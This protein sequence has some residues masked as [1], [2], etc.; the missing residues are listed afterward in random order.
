MR[1]HLRSPAGARRCADAR[2]ARYRGVF[3]S[4]RPDPARLCPSVDAEGRLELRRARRHHGGAPCARWNHGRARGYRHGRRRTRHMERPRYALADPRAVFQGL[5]G[6]PLGAAGDR[7][8]AR[9]E[10]HAWVRCSGRRAR[11]HRIVSRGDRSRIAVSGAGHH[12]RC[13]V[14][15]ALW[16]RGGARLRSRRR[17]RGRGRGRRRSARRASAGGDRA[18]GGCGILRALSRGAL[19]APAHHPRGRAHAGVGTRACTRE[20][21]KPAVRRRTAGQVSRAC[22]T[23][24]R[25]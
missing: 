6:L 15:P 2:S 10:T 25:A 11:A 20:S 4:T 1:R 9:A 19:G 23:R 12:R 13:P 5:P 16:R 14:Q 17:R 22:D 3:G 8:G 24:S 18:R 7:G 21:G